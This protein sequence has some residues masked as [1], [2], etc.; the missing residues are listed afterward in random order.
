LTAPRLKVVEITRRERPYKLRMPFRFGVMTATHGQ[1]A[2]IAVRIRLED[3]RE[4]TG[5]AAEAL[6]AKW[7]DKNP[8]LSDDDNHHQLRKAIELAGEAYLSAE[9]STAF[10]LFA[11]SYR[12]HLHICAAIDLNPLV[13][14]YGPALIDR[15]VFDALCRIHEASFYQATRSNLAG[16]GSHPIAPELDGVDMGAL[17]RA[18]NP[19][20]TI[21]VRHTV[22]LLDPITRADQTERIGDGLPET[23]EEVVATYGNRYFKIK[24]GGDDAADLERLERIA[25]V[26]DRS[27]EPYFLTLDGN[28]QYESAERA[29]V[30][31][32]RMR[33]SERLRR[34]GE[35]MLYLEQPIKRTVAL[36][37]PVEAL[38]AFT[39][40]IID[41]SDGD[42]SSFPR[43]RA[44][45]YR[46]VSSKACKGFYKSLINLV[47]CRV[48]NAQG[49][50]RHFMSA[51]DLTCEPGVALQQD[52][53]L[54]NMLG[55]THVERNAH[56]FIDGFD[57]RPEAEALAW[58]QAHPDLY[59]LQGG[60][61]RLAITDGRLGMGSLDIPGF[62]S[63][64]VPDLEATE[65]MPLS[66][67]PLGNAA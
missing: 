21:H 35:S 33:E 43:A 11:D 34:L 59:A 24:V 51:E 44:L 15:A 26:L 57:G 66:R 27:A 64:A 4:G 52:L 56:H 46:G 25:S 63:G 61:V 65:P 40:V 17:L 12:S 50:D 32:R 37:Q 9:P 16:I 67:W 2:V 3:G 55:L 36:S 20:S 1:Q 58:R 7:F 6:G 18:L 48:W 10:G 23:L 49:A 53:A 39:P 47:R 42:L 41:E 62:G 19:A 31:L 22:G 8:A 54:V 5:Y 13:A 60:R 45:G 30:L 38:A 14:S 29:L 28:E